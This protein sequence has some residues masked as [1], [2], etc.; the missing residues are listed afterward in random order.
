MRAMP[1]RFLIPAAFLAVAGLL[2][3]ALTPLNAQ[4]QFGGMQL[5]LENLR[6]SG[7]PVIPIFD[8]WIPKE[9]GSHDLCFA[10][11]S[12][13]LEEELD[14]PIGPDNLVEPAVFDGGQPTHF[15]AVP[16]EYRRHYCAFIVTVPPDF[17]DQRVVW[18]LTVHGKTYSVPGHTQRREYFLEDLYQRSEDAIAPSLGFLEPVQ[19]EAA[20]GRRGVT[21]GPATAAVGTPLTLTVSVTDEGLQAPTGD[22]PRGFEV[23]W[24][25]HQGPGGVSFDEKSVELEEGETTATTTAT[26]SEPGDYVLRVV[27]LNGSFFQH[28][29]WTTGY[30]NVTVTP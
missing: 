8:G 27:A 20:R 15:H 18:S 7:Q 26:F 1:G 22:E 28:C 4:Q 25:W 2:A 21:A 14:I 17:G 29:C 19:S 16:P 9:D 23:Y 24:Y 13:N 10:Y 11:F 30:L 3:G 6:P 12:L 5:M